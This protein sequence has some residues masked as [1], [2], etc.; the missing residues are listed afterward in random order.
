MARTVSLALDLPAELSFDEWAAMGRRV[1]QAH[2][3][4]PWLLGDWLLYGK[5]T[6][7]RRY[8]DAADALG[9][10]AQTLRVYAMVAG[11]FRP[12]RRRAALSFVHH[13]EV[14]PLGVAERER[15]LDEAEAEGWSTR[16]LH[17]K[18]AEVRALH[19]VAGEERGLEPGA[20]PGPSADGVAVVSVR[21]APAAANRWAAAADAAG[22][23]LDV[24]IASVLDAAAERSLAGA[25]A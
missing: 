24:W 22:V 21:V 15:L 17:A 1:A 13:R 2:N 7:G 18:V 14:V 4:T 16:D 23:D 19:R 5:F 9:V 20:D 11:H 25:A 3:A 6:Y 8:Q 12:E 10:E